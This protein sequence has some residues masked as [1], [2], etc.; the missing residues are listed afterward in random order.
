MN[1]E[2]EILADFRRLLTE[3]GVRARWQGKTI[4]VLAS[5]AR[6]EQQL[7]IGGY[8]S[9]PEVTLRFIKSDVSSLPKTGDRIEV[10]GTDH[11]VSRVSNHPRSPILTLTLT[12]TDE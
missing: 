8:V 4:D 2:A 7:D 3:R 5:R 6:A 1:L 12:T 9:S 10:D 11:R